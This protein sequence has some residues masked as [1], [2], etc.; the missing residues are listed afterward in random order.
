MLSPI[1]D[2]LPQL[3]P[4]LGRQ[5]CCCWFLDFDSLSVVAL[6]ECGVFVLGPVC[7]VV[8]SALSS[9]HSSC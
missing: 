3:L 1:E 5:L 2:K 7:D 9:I 6:N 4:I 8:L